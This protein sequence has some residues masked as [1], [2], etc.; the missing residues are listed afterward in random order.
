MAAKLI[1]FVCTS[2]TCRS[3][4]AEAFAKRYLE[5][6]NLTG[7]FEVVSRSMSTEY[8]PVGSPA[9]DYGVVV[10]R[11]DYGLDTTQHRSTLISN[12]CAEKASIMI[13]VTQNHARYLKMMFPQHSHKI[14]S[15]AA[16]VSDPWHQPIECYR[17]CAATMQPLVKDAMDLAT[18]E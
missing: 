17:L 13:G 3:P 10:M 16:D 8:E 15:L 12:E 7:R 14:R 2:N 11:D 1:V 6:N 5:E 9:S 4:M 18:S